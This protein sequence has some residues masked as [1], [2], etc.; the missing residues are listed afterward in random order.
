MLVSSASSRLSLS[1]SLPTYPTPHSLGCAAGARPRAG[2][3][4]TGRLPALCPDASAGGA[5]A[6]AAAAGLERPAGSRPGPIDTRSVVRSPPGG[7]RLRRGGVPRPCVVVT[8]LVLLNLGSARNIREK[9]RT[10][11]KRQPEDCTSPLSPC[12]STGT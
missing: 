8:F 4:P 3:A 1:L 5:A 9:L 12:A 7:G 10:R 2:A 6:V 11:K